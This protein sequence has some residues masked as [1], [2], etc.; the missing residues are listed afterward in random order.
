MSLFSVS[1]LKMHCGVFEMCLL[2]PNKEVACEHSAT[3]MYMTKR[4]INQKSTVF[5]NKTLQLKWITVFHSTNC[6]IIKV[7]PYFYNTRFGV[8]KR[9]S[10][11]MEK[12]KQGPEVN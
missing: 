9:F 6:K 11:C 3:V 4:S 1:A 10:I 5:F 12:L 2:R 7:F 8:S